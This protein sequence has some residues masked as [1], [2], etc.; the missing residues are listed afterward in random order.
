MTRYE[1]EFRKRAYE[2]SKDCSVLALA[3]V[4]GVSYM[5]AHHAMA[6]VG[7]IKQ[8]GT[9]PAFTRAA[10]DFLG[11]EV[12]RVWTAKQLGLEARVNPRLKPA[13]A[14]LEDKDWLPRMMVFVNN[15]DH[16]APF[17]NGHVQ[18]WSANTEAEI[19]EAWEIAKVGV[20][21]K[22]K[23]PPVIFL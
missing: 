23:T 20:A 5:V 1:E 11:F 2:G 6:A 16:V 3:S 13:L 21:I 18:D 7:R 8:G 17:F 14:D 12:R 19:D 15:H 22:A 9:D 4:C 10:L